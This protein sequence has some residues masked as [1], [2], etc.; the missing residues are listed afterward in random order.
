MV[1]LPVASANIVY[2]VRDETTGLIQY[3]RSSVV[4]TTL[5]WNRDFTVSNVALVDIY[6]NVS[7]FNYCDVNE[8]TQPGVE[9]LLQAHHV[10]L[11]QSW[12]AVVPKYDI[13]P[14][15]MDINKDLSREERYILNHPKR[16]VQY[17]Q[18][19]GNNV[20]SFHFLLHHLKVNIYIYIKI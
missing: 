16:H 5:P 6:H 19:L 2:P 17:I 10:P 20:P 9:R 7:V 8:Y 11:N 1:S 14:E 18:S 15:C 4:Q 3:N 13:V 12:V